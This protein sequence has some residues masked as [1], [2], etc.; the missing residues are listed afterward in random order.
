M[1]IFIINQYSYNKGDRAVLW[2]LLRELNLNGVS[3]VNV[4]TKDPLSWKDVDFGMDMRVN[5]VHWGWYGSRDSNNSCRFKS[6]IMKLKGK[7]LHRY[8]YAI[9]R[10]LTNKQLHLGVESILCN[11]DYYHALQKADLVISTGGHRITTW[12]APN[13]VSPQCFD[14][15]LVVLAKKRL[16]LWSQSVGPLE[17]S[18]SVDKKF[19]KTILK[20]SS[21]IYI[22]DDSSLDELRA[23]EIPERLVIKTKESVFGLQDAME[24]HKPPTEREFLAGLAVY[25]AKRRTAK[26]HHHYVRTLAALV[27]HAIQ[28]GFAL[29]L[30][31]MSIKG[32]GS[33]DRPLLQ[34]I[35]NAAQHG[36]RA[37]LL[38]I[39]LNTPNHLQQ[40]RRCRL[41]IGH[42]THSVLFALVAGTP[43]V[44]IAY[45]AKTRDFMREY[46]L[47]DYC[48]N[49]ADLCESNLIETFDRVLERIND[50]SQIEIEKSRELC[51]KVHR[52][53][54]DMLVS[55]GF[56]SEKT[57]T[58]ELGP[59]VE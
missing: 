5:F 59:E 48:I 54:R 45:H 11:R 21:G 28:R 7:I 36:K 19:I 39:D 41:F 32:S 55:N 16:V 8:A 25:R 37:V 12:L 57:W 53:F 42:K 26:E 35:I 23:I 49:D 6:A 51:G 27:D 18:N 4:S 31:P 29:H 22:R 15:A 58:S 24:H 33:D 3:Q 13:A 50:I 20:E 52:D 1:N 2:S 40:V 47:I 9:V 30:Y 46:N 44:G 56:S 14:L 38:D 34:E 17:F 10:Y 43:V